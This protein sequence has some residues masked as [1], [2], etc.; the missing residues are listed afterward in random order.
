[1]KP[2]EVILFPVMT[3][4]SVYMIENE[5]KLVFMVNRNANKHDVAEAVRVL[6]GVQTESVRTLITRE[7]TKKAFVRLKEGEDASDLAIRLGIL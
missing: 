2:H 7:G 5:N 6:Y 1:V 4:R 3:E